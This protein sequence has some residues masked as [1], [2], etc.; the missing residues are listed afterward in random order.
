L[1]ED[2]ARFYVAVAR[3]DI[4]GDLVEVQPGDEALPE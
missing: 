4:D 3:G 1:S 2:D